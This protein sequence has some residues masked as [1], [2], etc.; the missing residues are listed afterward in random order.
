MQLSDL[1]GRSCC[2]HKWHI[3]LHFDIHK[4]IAYR[5]LNRSGQA[6]LVGDPQDRT[7]R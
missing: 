6:R 4:T 3:V 5:I 2:Q 1:Q 7:D